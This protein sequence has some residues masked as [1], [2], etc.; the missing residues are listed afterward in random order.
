V[1]EASVK[2]SDPRVA[3]YATRTLAWMNDTQAER[4]RRLNL[5]P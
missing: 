3:D 4:R 5:A 1:L 2:S